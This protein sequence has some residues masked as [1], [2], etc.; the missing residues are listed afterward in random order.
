MLS[1]RG[2][3][4]QVYRH[5]GEIQPCVHGGVVVVVG[6][7]AQQYSRHVSRRNVRPTGPASKVPKP[8]MHTNGQTKCPGVFNMGEGLV[9]KGGSRHGWEAGKQGGGRYGKVGEGAGK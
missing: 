9:G 5:A 3:Q 1:H 8:G 6:V 4:Q 2:N 7:K